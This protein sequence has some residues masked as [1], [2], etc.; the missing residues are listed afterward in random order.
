MP[1]Y[2]FI[3][4]LQRLTILDSKSPIADFLSDN[5]NSGSFKLKTKIA[6]RTENYSTENVEIMVQLK[7]S[8]NFG[9]LVKR[10]QLI[11]KLIFL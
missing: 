9:Q 2:N 1:V 7:Y 6:G 4:I 8:S 3:T 5:N 10:H 11:M